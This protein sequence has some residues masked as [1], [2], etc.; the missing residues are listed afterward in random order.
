MF[1]SIAAV[2]L[3]FS[4]LSLLLLLLILHVIYWLTMII[5]SSLSLMLTTLI[6][7]RWRFEVSYDNITSVRQNF[8]S[9]DKLLNSHMV[10]PSRGCSGC[11]VVVYPS[12]GCSGYS[13]VVYTSKVVQWIL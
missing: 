7:C 3:V 8:L 4:S 5:F 1:L 12:R 6:L 9:K 13:D 10:Y 2:A 11:S